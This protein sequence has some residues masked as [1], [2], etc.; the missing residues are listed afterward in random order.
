MRAGIEEKESVP[1]FFAG[2]CLM[3]LMLYSMTGD[4]MAECIAVIQYESNLQVSMGR[5]FP[6]IQLRDAQNNYKEALGAM[7]S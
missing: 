7:V 5:A 4:S 2:W 3:I 6:D 1:A